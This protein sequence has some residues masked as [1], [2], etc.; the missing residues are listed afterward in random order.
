L[1]SFEKSN[2]LPVLE[3]D[4]VVE[5]GEV[6]SEDVDQSSS[7]VISRLYAFCEAALVFL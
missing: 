1:S 3:A 5:T 6:V 2:I 7:G 4:N